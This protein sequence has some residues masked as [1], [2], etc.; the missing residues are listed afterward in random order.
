MGTQKICLDCRLR[1]PMDAKACPRCG[2]DEYGIEAGEITAPP[3]PKPPEGTAPP[4]ISWVFACVPRTRC[5]I[6]ATP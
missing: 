2:G 5:A 1:F 4:P 3:F 6:L